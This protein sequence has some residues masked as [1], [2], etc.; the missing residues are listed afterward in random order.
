MKKRLRLALINS[1]IAGGLVFFG[2]F[3]TGNISY[4]GVLASV[5]A[6]GIVFLT[7]MR[8]YF[9]RIKSKKGMKGGIFEFF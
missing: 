1:A 6:F 2:S 5:S 4:Q 3:S 8:S 7:K 9:N